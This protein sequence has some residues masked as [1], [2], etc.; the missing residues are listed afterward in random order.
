M[1][2]EVFEV[3]LKALFELSGL[4]FDAGRLLKYEQLILIYL[5]VFHEVNSFK[6]YSK[7]INL[8]S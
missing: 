4:I 7:P 6:L 3:F 5:M 1:R 8:E 2:G